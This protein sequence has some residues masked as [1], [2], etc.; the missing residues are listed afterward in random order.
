MFENVTKSR[1][2]VKSILRKRNYLIAF[3]MV[4]IFIFAIF[5]ILTLATVTNQSI[6]IFIMMNGLA[7]TVSTFILFAVISLLFGV[8]VVLLA[9]SMKIHL[10]RRVR[11]SIF[12]TGGLIAGIFGAGCPMCGS[13]IFA[14]FGMPLALFFLPFKGLEL[15]ALSLLLLGLSVYLLSISLV[16][17]KI[18][19][20]V[21][22]I[23]RG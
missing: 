16:N 2:I 9:F 13:A 14:L 1:E 8:Y 4:S 22:K 15:R 5:Y 18:E 12:G 19:T 7:Y 20:K 3:I 23:V 21:I 10:K 17:C 11:K 6:G